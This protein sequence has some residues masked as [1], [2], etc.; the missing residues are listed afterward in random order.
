LQWSTLPTLAWRHHDITK[1]LQCKYAP[2]ALQQIN[3]SLCAARTK[4]GVN[5]WLLCRAREC[6]KRIIVDTN[7]RRKIALRRAHLA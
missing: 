6:R 7:Q 1:L 3:V 4:C 5:A 2:C